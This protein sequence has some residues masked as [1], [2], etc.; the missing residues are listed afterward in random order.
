M[1]RKN[2]SLQ[3]SSSYE[4]LNKSSKKIGPQLKR[5]RP[6]DIGR[7]IKK[8]IYYDCKLAEDLNDEVPDEEEVYVKENLLKKNKEDEEE[9]Y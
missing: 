1:K 9:Y 2:L 7:R 6:P 3:N 8:L 5:A 4:H